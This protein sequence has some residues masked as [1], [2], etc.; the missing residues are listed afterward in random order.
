MIERDIANKL[1]GWNIVTDV[2]KK[3]NVTKGTSYVYLSKLEK[4]GFIIQK[5]KKPRGTMYLID[6]IPNFSKKHGMLEGTDIVSSEIEFSKDQIPSEHKIAYFLKKSIDD[7][8]IRYIQEAEKLIRR[9][10]NWKDLYKYLKAYNV[11]KEFKQ[12][13]VKSRKQ[14]KKVPSI[15]ERYRKL[16]GV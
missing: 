12:F 11:V 13:Y 1:K 7:K 4:K 5:I 6:P 14:I 10:K 16:I 15:P 3:L 9:I 2:S 8:N